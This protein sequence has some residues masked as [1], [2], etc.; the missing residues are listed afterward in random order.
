MKIL[1]SD[2]I[3]MDEKGGK[4]DL[5]TD[6]EPVEEV[7]DESEESPSS[8]VMGAEELKAFVHAVLSQLD[9]ILKRVSTV[10]REVI[11][12]SYLLDEDYFD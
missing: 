6:A 1:E 5:Q 3:L 7:V 9:T 11:H 2:T 8:P 12:H 4:I 10:I